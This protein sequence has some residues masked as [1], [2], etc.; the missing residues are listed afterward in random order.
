V[1]LLKAGSGVGS[2][3]NDGAD[4]PTSDAVATS[5]GPQFI[6]DEASTT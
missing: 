2:Q 4:W 6:V 3:F 1:Q 5:G